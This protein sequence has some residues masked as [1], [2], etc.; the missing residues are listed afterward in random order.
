[1]AVETR[2]NLNPLELAQRLAETSPDEAAFLAKM[3]SPQAVL[4]HRSPYGLCVC[5]TVVWEGGIPRPEESIVCPQCGAD[6]SIPLPFL[7]RI[8]YGLRF[9]RRTRRL[10]CTMCHKRWGWAK[11]REIGLLN[12]FRLPREIEARAQRPYGKNRPT[13]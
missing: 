7:Q 1:M 9:I 13:H 6:C 3:L 2:E 4:P 12:A 10:K 8:R 5:G 11:I